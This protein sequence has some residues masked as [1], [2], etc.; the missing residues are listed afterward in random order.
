M[1]GACEVVVSGD[2]ARRT[3][4]PVSLEDYLAPAQLEMLVRA[5]AD[6][7]EHGRGEVVVTV[8]GG[9]VTWCCA[10]RDYRF[11]DPTKEARP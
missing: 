8:S 2:T 6:V 5:L 10:R 11:P 3:Y 9:H 4:S 7:V 1:A